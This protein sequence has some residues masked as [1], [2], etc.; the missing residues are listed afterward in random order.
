[1]ILALTACSTAERSSN[2]LYQQLGKE[3]GIQSIVDEFLYALAD[4]E[5]VLPLFANT[6]IERFREQFALQ[7]CALAGGPCVYTGDSMADTHRGMKINHAQF[8]TV[9]SDLIVAME[10]NEVPTGAQNALLAKLAPMFSDIA[11]Q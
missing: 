7:L 8:N 2:E 6:N 1:M 5:T 11:E 4:N 10:R 3:P 9:V